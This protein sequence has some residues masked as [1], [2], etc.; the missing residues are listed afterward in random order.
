[1][2]SPI[3]PTV[4]M[5]ALGTPWSAQIC[6]TRSPVISR[7]LPICLNV[8]PCLRS[9]SNLLSRSLV[10][11]VLVGFIVVLSALFMCVLGILRVVIM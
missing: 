1:M 7:I 4:L 8:W 3:T 9:S 10:G 2:C 5:S 6:R 11:G